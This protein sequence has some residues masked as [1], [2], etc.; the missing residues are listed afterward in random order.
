MTETVDEA[1]ARPPRALAGIED[2]RRATCGHCQADGPAWAC[3]FSGTGLT[4][5]TWPASRVGPDRTRPGVQRSV[6]AG[7]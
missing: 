4:A 5:C 2:A 6:H 3:S 1:Q 7:T